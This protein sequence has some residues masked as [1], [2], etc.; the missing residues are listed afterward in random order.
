VELLRKGLFFA[1]LCLLTLSSC[2]PLSLA[3]EDL[4]EP[5]S[6][7]ERQTRVEA[8]LDTSLGLG[9]ITWKY[10]Q[11]GDYRSPF[12]FR[13]LDR[14]GLEEA[15]VFY[16]Y[17]EDAAEDSGIVRAKV[18][19]E[20]EE[21]DW[22]LAYDLTGAGD[23]VDFVAFAPVLDVDGECLLVGWKD[24]G[25]ASGGATLSVYSFLG[26]R[27]SPELET[28]YS[29][30]DYGDYQGDG[31]T[32]IA[33]V[34]QDFSGEYLLSLMGRMAEGIIAPIGEARLATQA[35]GVHQVRRSLLWNN[36]WGVLV[37]EINDDN[38]TAT[39]IFEVS[40]NG[41]SAVVSEAEGAL[42]SQTIRADDM[43]STD[44]HS[45]GTFCVPTISSFPGDV[46][47]S[48]LAPPPLITWLRPS[49]NGEFVDVEYAVINE[50]AGYMFFLPLRWMDNVTILRDLESNEW[51]FYGID[52][53]T[54]A[55]PIEL[56]RIW[57]YDVRD[58][59]DSFTD[60]YEKITERGLFQYYA[61]IPPLPQETLAVTGPE[62]A[63]LFT[64]L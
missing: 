39:E 18:L 44:L 16:V 60:Y 55:P 2:S 35:V 10:P 19:K 30:L 7:T 29:A 3:P 58:Y 34:S 42:Y 1:A 20:G 62:V 52:Q 63:R 59:R 57:V 37:D 64:L 13:D 4:L 6:L 51:R 8:A 46:P 12:V 28:E 48:D 11:S 22:T 33:V 61:W 50:F 27:L 56:L 31:L 40:K 26:G 36:V 47:E 32:E 43:L 17:N 54:Q 38:N 25:S 9:T 23:Q 21:G 24:A 14:D 45:N 15:I 49:A 41:L 53:E 5:P